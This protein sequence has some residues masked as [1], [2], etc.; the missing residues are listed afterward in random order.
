M[1]NII[2]TALIVYFLTGVM[3]CGWFKEDYN[4]CYKITKTKK[5]FHHCLE[6]GEGSYK[7]FIKEKK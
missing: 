2:I 6:T 3:V 7:K 4:E 5:D 1:K